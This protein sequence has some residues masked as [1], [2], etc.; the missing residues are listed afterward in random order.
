MVRSLAFQAG[1]RILGLERLADRSGPQ[2]TP[3]QLECVIL[4]GQGKGDQDIGAL[5]SLSPETVN[6]YL[7]NARER[8]GVRTRMQLVMSAVFDGE[9]GFQEVIN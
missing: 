4:A 1:R 6:S 7:D 2:L 5:L 8:Y 9:I 3:R